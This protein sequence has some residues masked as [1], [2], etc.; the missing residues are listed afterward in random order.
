MFIIIYVW[1]LRWKIS[2]RRFLIHSFL[3]PG[4][5]CIVSPS[6]AIPQERR[7]VFVL[8]SPIWAA[9]F[10][11]NAGARYCCLNISKKFKSF[12]IST[13]AIFSCQSPCD[14][15]KHSQSGYVYCAQLLNCV[16]THS[17]RYIR[18]K[19]GI[20]FGRRYRL[21]GR[22]PIQFRFGRRFRTMRYYR[23]K[24]RIRFR[25]KRRQF[26]FIGGR[27][28]IFYRKTWVRPRSRRTIRR[29]RRRRTRRRLR[30]RKR[31]RRRRLRRRRRGGRRRRGCVMRVFFRRRYRN[32]YRRGRRL[33]LRFKRGYR[34]VR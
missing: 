25:K 8:L 32:I 23:G 18:G 2:A 34:L 17:F 21:L 29:R 30:R 26:R 24:P 14:T 3:L 28:R 15:L 12:H 22:R 11:W 13:V 10:L 5:Y 9:L 33:F 4:V 20:R 19:I 31:R 16:S 6:L 27:L 7:Y 1:V